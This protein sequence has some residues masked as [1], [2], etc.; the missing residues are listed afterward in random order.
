MYEAIITV[1]DADINVTDSVGST[2]E[3]IELA[4]ASGATG[5][6]ITGAGLGS[7]DN[8]YESFDG[9]EFVPTTWDAFVKAA[10]DRMVDAMAEAE[11][12]RREWANLQGMAGGAGAYNDAMG[13]SVEEG[14]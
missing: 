11:H 9:Y 1:A 12:A 10:E 5:V 3:L 14:W 7:D 4:V 8:N 13:W 6:M 2:K